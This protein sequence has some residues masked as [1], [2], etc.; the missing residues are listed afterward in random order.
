LL[1]TQTSGIAGAAKQFLQHARGQIEFHFQRHAGQVALDRL[2]KG[3]QATGGG[4]FA[5]ADAHHPGRPGK[6][7]GIQQGTFEPGPQWLAI[8]HQLA[9][10]GGQHHAAAIAAEYGDAQP[11]LQFAHAGGNRRLA[12]VQPL[13]RRAK[14][15][16][17]G[18]PQQGFQMEERYSIHNQLLSIMLKSY[19]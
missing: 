13:R 1:A 3:G 16:Q 4:D 18:D 8:L 12:G 6:A 14:G 5:G 10:L 19:H 11:L 17:P 9:A 2:D 15:A 7:A